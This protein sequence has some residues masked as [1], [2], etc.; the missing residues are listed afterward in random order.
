MFPRLQCILELQNLL[1]IK[2]AE[3]PISRINILFLYFMIRRVRQERT[4]TRAP[5]TIEF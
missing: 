4:R 5:C 3:L 1:T 2:I